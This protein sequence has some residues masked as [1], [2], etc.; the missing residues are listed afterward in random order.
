MITIRLPADTEFGL[1]GTYTLQK[2]SFFVL[3]EGFFVFGIKKKDFM[4]PNNN[5][6]RME[7][8]VVYNNHKE[9]Y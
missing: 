2:P 8:L 9:N 6:D 3:K 5:K 4:L 7:R 1:Q